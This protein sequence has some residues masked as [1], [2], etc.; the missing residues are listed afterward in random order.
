MAPSCIH[1][2]T[3]LVQ[4]LF[5]VSPS[6]HG[7]PR[8]QQGAPPP[9]KPHHCCLSA[10]WG[11]GSRG[12]IPTDACSLSILVK[13]RR[14]KMLG[15]GAPGQVDASSRNDL[16]SRGLTIQMAPLLQAHQGSGTPPKA[17]HS[18]PL[19]QYSCLENPRGQRSRSSVHGVA[20]SQTRLIDFHIF[21]DNY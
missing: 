6:P 14:Q 9:P 4:I 5:P 7:L 10:A 19:G 11:P 21:I 2:F 1:S 18:D 17:E 15:L 13:E 8:D 16:L 12:F 3:H 20:K